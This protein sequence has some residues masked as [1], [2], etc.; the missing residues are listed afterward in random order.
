MTEDGDAVDEEMSREDLDGVIAVLSEQISRFGLGKPLSIEERL[1]QAFL[2]YELFMCDLYSGQD[3]LF[4]SMASPDSKDT[5]R[6]SLLKMMNAKAGLPLAFSE[7]EMRLKL[8]VLP[9]A[10]LRGILTRVFSD[11]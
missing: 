1:Y 8:S 3:P 5:A 9:D 10:D 2:P 11:P 6:V 4:R 7:E